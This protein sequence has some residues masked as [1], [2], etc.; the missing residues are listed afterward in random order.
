[1]D[2]DT[3]TGPTIAASKVEGTTVYNPNGDKLGSIDDLSI[4]KVSGRVRYA[5]LEFGGFLG[6][7]TDRYPMPWDMLRYDLRHDGYVVNLTKSQLEGAPHHPA[8]ARPEYTD[9]Y[10]REVYDYYGKGWL[11]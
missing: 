8:D 7:G 1:M 5:T 11:D 10:G 6:I 2:T 3:T 4:D 9:A